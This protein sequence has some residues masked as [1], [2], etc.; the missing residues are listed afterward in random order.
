MNEQR[1]TQTVQEGYSLFNKGDIP[2]LLRLFTDDI[3]II[4][5]G[6]PDV[7][8]YAGVYR[9]QEQVTT[10]FTKLHQ[11]V[12]YERFEA[13]EL[14]AQG[15][16]VVALGYSKGQIRSNG[17]IIEE[18]WAHVFELQGEKV[19]RLQVFTDTAAVVQAFQTNKKMAF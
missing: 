17:Q 2:N 16:K 14:I 3:E 5:P 4:I 7:I 15:N 10:F 8:P 1:N 13:Q 6:T 18:E 12:Q 9:G 11:A 19:S